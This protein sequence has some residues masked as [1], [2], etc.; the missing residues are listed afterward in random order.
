[1]ERLAKMTTEE[2]RAIFD[3][4]VASG[5]SM[6]ITDE[7]AKRL[8]RWRLETKIAV[9]QAFKELVQAKG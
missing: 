5:D 2:S 1:M 4:L 8:L 7:E 3:E 9:R 6:P